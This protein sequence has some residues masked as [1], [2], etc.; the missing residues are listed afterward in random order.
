[1]ETATH[2]LARFGKRHLLGDAD[3]LC[4]CCGGKWDREGDGERVQLREP[5]FSKFHLQLSRELLL[6]G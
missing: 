4:L 1:M 3:H 6:P 5:A 2:Q